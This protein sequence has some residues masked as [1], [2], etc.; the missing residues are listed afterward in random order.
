MESNYHQPHISDIRHGFEFEYLHPA[1]NEWTPYNWNNPRSE[2]TIGFNH[3]SI[4]GFKI[5]KNKMRVKEKQPTPQLET[6]EQY[7][8]SQK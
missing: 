1:T 4:C 2:L 7:E 6:I 8:H 5:E 3:I